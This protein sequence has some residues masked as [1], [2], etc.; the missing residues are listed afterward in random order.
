MA[1]PVRDIVSSVRAHADAAIGTHARAATRAA[2]VGERILDAGQRGARAVR[3]WWDDDGR[4][5]TTRKHGDI[6]LPTEGRRARGRS[7]TRSR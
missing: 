2:G 3:R 6:R 5:N 1:D 7:Q 4:G